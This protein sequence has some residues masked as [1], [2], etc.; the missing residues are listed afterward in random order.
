M[1]QELNRYANEIDELEQIS[2][3]NYERI[4]KVYK[5]DDFYAYNILKTVKIPSDLH[6]DIFSYVRVTGKTSWVHVS[7]RVY[8]NIKLWWLICL[9]N[10][11]LNPVVLPEPTLVLRVIKPQFVP[12]VLKAINDQ[13]Q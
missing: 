13:L 10:G 4:F 1:K 2:S 5:D 6:D 7:H 3:S 9:T 12:E 8:G 11:I